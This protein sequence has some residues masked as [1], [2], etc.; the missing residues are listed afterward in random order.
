MRFGVNFAAPPGSK[1]GVVGRTGAGKS[2]L[3]AA[4][5][6]LTEPRRTEAG[7]CGVLIDGVDVASV[8]LSLLRRAVSVIP[9]EPVLYAGTLRSNLDPFCAA[10]DAECWEALE[11]VRL[12][13]L[14]AAPGRGG[15]S[16]RV[17][18]SGCNLSAGQRQLVCLARAILRRCMVV[19]VDEATANVDADTDAAIQRAIRTHFAGA[20]VI[21]IAHRLQTIMDS[22]LVIVV[23][24]GRVK[25]AGEP[26]ALTKVPGGAF[27]ELLREAEAK[28]GGGRR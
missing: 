12:S 25:E 26:G 17:E 18:E 21:T 23:G 13:P 10:T 11:A 8:P 6:R 15:L 20:T 22:D 3:L 28:S 5:L 4:L 16:A 27:A 2:S 7:G 1:L 9:Q 14:F 19:V 24:E